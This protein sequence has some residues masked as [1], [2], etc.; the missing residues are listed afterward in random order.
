ME[1]T[2]NSLNNVNEKLVEGGLNMDAEC[3]V[4]EVMEKQLTE[5]K[6]K[7]VNIDCSRCI[8]KLI[9]KSLIRP[10]CMQI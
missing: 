10:T 2:N 9:D 1:L 8:L 5:K 6:K 7:K 3:E 4:V